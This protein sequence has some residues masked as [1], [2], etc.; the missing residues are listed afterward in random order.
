[1]LRYTRMRFLRVL[2]LLMIIVALVFQG[3]MIKP[4]TA[5]AACN[6]SDY[7]CLQK[8]KALL[9]QQAIEKKQRAEQKK[10]EA[11]NLQDAVRSLEEDIQDTADQIGTTESQITN[12]NNVI[13]ALT[14]DIEVASGKLTELND[15]LNKAYADLYELSQTSTVEI[16]LGSNTLDDAFSQTQYI[17]SIQTNLQGSIAEHDRLKTEL[18]TKKLSSEAEKADL[19]G[20]RANLSNTKSSL[21]SKKTIKNSLLSATNNQAAQYLS[22][23]NDLQKRIAEIDRQVTLLLSKKNWGT[24]IFS[25]NDA[26]W[27]YSQLDYP[28]VRMG[29]SWYTLDKVGCLVTSY[30]MVS[31]Y[32]GKRVTPPQIASYSVNFDHNGFLIKQ[33]PTPTGLSSSTTQSINWSVVNSELDASR[34]VIVSIYLREIGGQGWNYDGSHHF[35]VIKSRSG[36]KYFMHDPLGAGRSYNVGDVRS[37]KLIRK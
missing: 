12:A 9:Q 11:A 10:K 32:Y 37:M 8:E 19:E 36:S 3:L 21:S 22:D 28:G 18:E 25:S 17:Q 24:D 26:S 2:V 20:L 27:Y 7:V 13:A 30:A 5:L 29:N 15:K 1:M 23:Y 6:P 14:A 33:P 16:L 4:T 35:V 31:T 34:P